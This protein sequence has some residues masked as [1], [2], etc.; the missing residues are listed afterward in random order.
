MSRRLRILTLLALAPFA[1]VGAARA[2]RFEGSASIQQLTYKYKDD[3][4]SDR[5]KGMFFGASA[6]V[7]LGPVR[8]GLS[9]F[10]GQLSGGTALAPRSLRQ[11]AAN[12]GLRPAPWIEVGIEAQA[13]RE[14]VDTSVVLQR[15]GG[16]FT[17]FAADLG[18]NGL[19]GTA[20]LALFP[21]RSASG[22]EPLN[23]AM[24]AGVG[25]RYAPFGSPLT[26]E[27]GYRM[28]RLDHKSPD[29]GAVRLEQDES[30][31]FAVGLRR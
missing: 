14:A 4:G 5:L 26:L 22:I 20:E 10:T 28:F 3:V 12:I 25:V 15:L 16:V 17:R 7:F 30:L 23:A 18:T 27:L 1:G 2:Q 6:S 19:Q 8:L 31:V 13:R 11:T 29:T 21:I 24:R 9:G